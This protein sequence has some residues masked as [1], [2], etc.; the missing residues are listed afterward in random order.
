MSRI[1][2]LAAAVVALTLAACGGGPLVKAQTP[3][4]IGNLQLVSPVDWNQFAFGRER[5]WTRDGAFL[6]SLLIY[7]NIR[8]REE[9]TLGPRRYGKFRYEGQLYRADMSEV[10]VMELFVDKLKS[11][12]G[13]DVQSSALRPAPFGSRKGFRF[14]LQWQTDTG[15]AVFGAGGLNYRGM[16]LAETQG[17]TLSYLYFGAPAEF[18]FG[19]DKAHVEEIFKRIASTGD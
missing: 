10:E 14:E 2:N 12:G 16:V 18:Y 8:D 1:A 3:V 13:V 9:L 19:R 5:M 11:Q 4:K 15:D 6:N 17:K 7:T